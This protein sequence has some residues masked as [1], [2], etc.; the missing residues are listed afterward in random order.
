MTTRL[1]IHVKVTRSGAIQAIA[2][3]VTPNNVWIG[4]VQSFPP[5][6]IARFAVTQIPE[7]EQG[8]PPQ[9]INKKESN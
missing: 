6:H 2:A 7:V 8:R 1:C 3:C 4:L 9:T 5:Y